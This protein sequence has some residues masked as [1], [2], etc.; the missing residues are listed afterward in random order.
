M[1]EKKSSGLV[2]AGE[3]R[4][5]TFKQKMNLQGKSYLISFG[6]VGFVSN[7]FE[8]YHRIYDACELNVISDK[9]TVG[10]YD[11]NSEVKINK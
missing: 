8:V 11:M 5:I 7:E 9:N 6:C 1:Y 4:I 2:N 10:F 3:D